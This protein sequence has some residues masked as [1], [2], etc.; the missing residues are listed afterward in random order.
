MWLNKS[1][2][3]H[4]RLL[5]VESWLRGSAR[6]AGEPEDQLSNSGND[7]SRPGDHNPREAGQLRLSAEL[8]ARQEVLHAVQAV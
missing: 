4:L 5:S 6:T 3:V 7:G 2:R 8:C 1:L